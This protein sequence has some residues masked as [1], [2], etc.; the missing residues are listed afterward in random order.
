[1]KLIG[2]LLVT[3]SVACILL[4]SA[5]LNQA[6]IDIEKQDMKIMEYLIKIDSLERIINEKEMGKNFPRDSVHADSILH[7]Y[8]SQGST[9]FWNSTPSAD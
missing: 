2:Y 3:L 4:G 7:R 8:D 5:R 1:M 9:Y 6:Y